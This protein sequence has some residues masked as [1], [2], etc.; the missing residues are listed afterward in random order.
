MADFA[1]SAALNL[2]KPGN[3]DQVSRLIRDK[4][5]NINVKVNVGVNSSAAGKINEVG[6]SLRRTSADSLRAADSMEAFGRQTAIT[7]RRFGAYTLA[8]AGFFKFIRSVN[9]GIKEA[10]QFQDQLVKIRQ[11]T[12]ESLSSLGALTSEIDR[13][14][15]TLGVS[16]KE[17]LDASQV[18]AQAGLNARE[19]RVALQALAKSDLAPTFDNINRTAESSIAILRQFGLNVDQLEAKLSSI[20]SVSAKFAVESG[21]ITSAIQRT[22]GAFAAAGGSLEE[23]I[24]LFTSVRATTRESA[25]S[26]ATGFRTIFT[27]IQRSRTQ[28]F[29][30]DL[31]VDLKDVGEEARKL[32]K[33]GLFVGPYKAVERLSEALGQL[34]SADPRFAQIVEELGGF[35]Q[36]SK[37]IPLVQQFAT[38]ENALGVALRGTNSLT[39]DADKRQE[40]L[41][42]QIKKVNEEFQVLLRQFGDSATFKV[43]SQTVIDLTRLLIRLGTVLEGLVAPMALVFAPLLAKG[44]GNFATGIR[45]KVSSRTIT[46]FAKGGQIGGV[47]NKDTELIAAMP[48]EF[49]VRKQS[50]NKYGAEFFKNLN[51]GKVA[52]FAGG[53]IVGGGVG[54]VVSKNLPTIGAIALLTISSLQ[55]SFGGLDK[56]TIKLT[57]TLTSAVLQFAVMSS[58]I[59]AASPG[60]DKLREVAEGAKKRVIRREGAL[61]FAKEGSDKRINELEKRISLS[62]FKGDPQQRAD[63]LLKERDKT[64]D[65]LLSPF[66]RNRLEAVNRSN[67]I[68]P[69]LKEKTVDIVK[70]DNFNRNRLNSIESGIKSAMLDKIRIQNSQKEIDAINNNIAQKQ[71]EVDEAKKIQ[72]QYERQAKL[73]NGLNIGLAAAATGLTIFG[74]LLSESANNNLAKLRSGQNIDVDSTRRSFVGGGAATAGG[75]GLLGGFALVN[76]ASSIAKITPVT[77]VVV[78]ALTG[79]GTAIYGY[80]NAQKEFEK[81]LRLIDIEKT[82][83]NLS[84]R[85]GD[86]QQGANPR[87]VGSQINDAIA[88]IT[89]QL[90]VETGKD[91]RD[92]LNATIESS[93]SGLIDFINKTRSISSS[94]ESFR[95]VV[96]TNTLQ[97]VADKTG[98]SLEEY[99]TSIDEA[100]KRQNEN[101]NGLENATRNIRQLEIGII[102]QRALNAA[103]QTSADSLQNFSSGLNQI[104][105]NAAVSF[106][107][108]ISGIF[109]SISS[110]VASRRDEGQLNQFASNFGPAA[111][112]LARTSIDAAK[113]IELLPNALLQI[114]AQDPLGGGTGAFADRLGILLDNA[115][116]GTEVRNA[117]LDQITNIIGPEGKDQ[118]VVERINKDLVGVIDEISSGLI[119]RN[120]DTFT[121]LETSTL[122]ALKNFSDGLDVA[123]KSLEEITDRRLTQ[124]DNAQLLQGVISNV[125]GRQN[126]GQQRNLERTRSNIVTGGRSSG[127]LFQDLRSSEDNEIQLRNQL[128]QT[129]DLEARK[130]IIS[131]ISSEQVARDKAKRGLDFLADASNRTAIAQKQLEGATKDRLT[132]RDLAIQSVFA[133]PQERAKQGFVVENARKAIAAGDINAIPPNLIQDVLSFLQGLGDTRIGALGGFSGNEGIDR[134]LTK[135]LG[136]AGVNQ[137]GIL[138]PGE[139]EKRL[140]TE[141]Q[142][143]VIQANAIQQALINK[144]GEQNNKFVADLG[145]QFDGFL[146]GLNLQISDIFTRERQTRSLSVRGDIEALAVQRQA[147]QG[148]SR[149]TG[150]DPQ[151]VFNSF[152][153]IKSLIT[154]QNKINAQ[155][156]GLGSVQTG[157]R[158]SVGEVIGEGTSGKNG[159]S[160]L[161]EL[162]SKLDVNQQTKDFLGAELRSGGLANVTQNIETAIKEG[163]TSIGRSGAQLSKE[164]FNSQIADIVSSR[165]KGDFD[166]LIPVITKNLQDNL[167]LTQLNR[168]NL[169]S[170]VGGED[171]LNSIIKN[172]SALE[173]IIKGL[174]QNVEF[175]KL[176]ESIR[177]LIAKLNS[178]NPTQP[179]GR[180]SGGPVGFGRSKRDTIP[181]MLADGEYVVQSSSVG[182]YG[183]DFLDKLNE[184]KLKGYRTGGRVK[185]EH[186]SFEDA[187]KKF[188]FPESIARSISEYGVSV[189]IAPK[190]TDIDQSLAFQQP[191]GQSKVSFEDVKG[192]YRSP[193]KEMFMRS[194]SGEDVF[195][196]EAG[197]AFDYSRG[198]I[199]DS[200]E[201]MAAYMKDFQKL[202]KEQRERFKYY[203]QEGSAGRR[204]S[205]AAIFDSVIRNNSTSSK[206]FPEST[207]VV[208]SQ[209]NKVNELY[210]QEKQAARNI[211][212]PQN[213]Q[214]SKEN[215]SSPQIDM[216]S[217]STLNTAIG[218]FNSTALELARA[219]STIP[220]SISLNANH[221][222]EVIHNGIQ[223]F[224]QMEQSISRLIISTT[225]KEIN[226]FIDQKFP[227]V[228]PMV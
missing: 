144:Q 102:S 22:G 141:V 220:S 3:L 70:R 45:T 43:V 148:I 90:T 42:I 50:V 6:R 52:K 223:I 196:H 186:Y 214:P 112:S 227:E 58:I 169:A 157:L 213:F 80:V 219:I 182:K 46:P 149:L 153:S 92:S 23:L 215:I 118:T 127:R 184:G 88:K 121:Q 171:N 82:S 4:L 39:E 150:V 225:N 63:F 48:G 16:S 89:G 71:K 119:S 17:L 36:I 86:L 37:V 158:S 116:I 84:N 30:G 59:K 180:S 57:S 76:F 167:G 96:S 77:A 152:E 98:K 145:T 209:I 85:L 146:K 165:I 136:A 9:Q 18:L 64:A 65:K 101:T 164:Q 15:T 143:G 202:N 97:L 19:V 28:N 129:Q 34:N 94:L 226:K 132:K 190:L 188:N 177:V 163:Y 68:S 147:G 55:N 154:E 123:R 91:P 195:T 74:S 205:F 201:Y 162:I 207:K 40:S 131:A 44:I 20:N 110:G 221:R 134:I 24:S 122:T 41:A 113:A 125:T 203:L 137:E 100:I 8:T 217:I 160:I 151:T 56:E 79:L 200:K 212:Q 179:I 114:R 199:S 99:I 139:D 83:V 117:I 172:L 168:S 81:Q 111:G 193:S 25:D 38:S 26:I 185:K 174:P 178:I 5:E 173:P 95:S 198:T 142:N 210:K 109:N 13:L 189:K 191:R 75:A 130:R 124:V 159:T 107:S 176:D 135:Q 66:Q 197:H 204:E 222:V 61:S 103:A 216:S 33:E 192:L 47:G 206:Y 51:E 175:G 72:T 104:V 69:E 105:T 2:Q 155:L 29:L 170:S 228:G 11:V 31:G 211:A 140:L 12:G 10:I 27:R 87:V 21:D 218:Q 93:V 1:L 53:G 208:N 73:V 108:G 54:S 138:T 7:I 67:A 224:S 161:S 32:G 62:N 115:N 183:L 126:F 128:A 60:L 166:Q 35:R 187:A 194:D 106:G 14:S 133:T 120:K 181:A 78:T 156:S 49:V